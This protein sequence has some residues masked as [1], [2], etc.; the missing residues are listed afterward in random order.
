MLYEIHHYPSDLI[1]VM[2]LTRGDDV[3]RIVVR[4]V[5]PQD[6]APTAAFFA[7][8]SPQSRS[9][10]FLAP[11]R[12]VAPGLIRRFTQ[13]DYKSHVALVAEVFEDGVETVIAEVR[14]VRGPD[15]RA[16]EFAVTVA[17]GWQGLG[18]AGKLLAKLVCHAAASG[19][20]VLTGE[21]LASNVAMLHLARKAGFTLTPDREMP[22]VVNLRR[23]L[24]MG[25]GRTPC[26][27]TIA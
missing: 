26:G 1:D 4:P 6:D 11:L 3:V 9:S 21:T 25:T 19:V 15:G 14:Y 5:L 23:L 12:E 8:L 27:A 22:S 7:A 18:L 2:H 16:A 20:E 13:V 24:P 10:R 17:E